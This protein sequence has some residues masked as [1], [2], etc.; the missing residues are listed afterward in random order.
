MKGDD[1]E[2]LMQSLSLKQ[3]ELCAHVMQAIHMKD[4]DMYNF[5]KV[6]VEKTRVDK[7]I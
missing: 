2:S 4:G 1:Y 6:G 3:S 5:I 7:T